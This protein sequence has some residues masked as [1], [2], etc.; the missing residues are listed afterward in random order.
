MKVVFIIASVLVY[1]STAYASSIVHTVF[2][3]LESDN[4][5]GVQT[6]KERSLEL[7]EIP[8]VEDF[9][10]V[11]ETSPK[12]DF[13]YGLT[14][15]FADQAAYNAYNI[16][17]QHVEYVERVW[18]PNVSDFMEIDY[19]EKEK[20]LQLSS[21]WTELI[22]SDLS[23][24]EVWTGVPHTSVKGL[25]PG[26]PQSS[27][28]NKGTPIGLSDPKEIYK[29]TTG[30]NG[31]LIL[32]VSGEIYAVL[33][34]KQDFSNYHLSLMF[35]WGDKKWEPRL[36]HKRDSGILYHCHG[37]H[38]SVGRVW[39]RCLEMQVQE[40]DCGDLICLGP[41]VVTKTSGEGNKKYWDPVNGTLKRVGGRVAHSNDNEKSYGEWNHFEVYVLGDDAI[42]VVNGEVVLAL[43]DAE[44]QE[45][46][47]LTEGQIQLQSEAAQCFYKDIKIRR[48]D[49]LPE[50]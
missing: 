30:E 25:P 36:K 8:G 35:K 21:E 42:H 39:K 16:H 47:P 34:T 12:N 7:A 4:V 6:F 40:G 3:T 37:M 41:T 10:W 38:G 44:Y 22:D 24:W 14:M 46:K 28:V 11:E 26:T 18:K 45:G 2:F 48:I 13:E 29:V 20:V 33:T 9:A 23:Y 1:A 50:F 5:L 15:R 27:N 17:P 49:Q 19:V 31:E 32:E 43:E